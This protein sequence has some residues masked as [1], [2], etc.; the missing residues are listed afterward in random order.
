LETLVEAY[1]KQALALSA[2]FP[3]STFK[4]N[5]MMELWE[6]DRP[7]NNKPPAKIKLEGAGVAAVNGVYTRGVRGCCRYSMHGTYNGHSCL[8]SIGRSVLG[9][10]K[11]WLISI[12]DGTSFYTCELNYRDSKSDADFP[13]HDG[14]RECN[15]GLTAPPKVLYWASTNIKCALAD[16]K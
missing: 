1:K 9:P 12:P 7:P 5:R 2:Q 11:R 4:T 3:L 15:G 10:T 8:L 14:W 13:P 16:K 6:N